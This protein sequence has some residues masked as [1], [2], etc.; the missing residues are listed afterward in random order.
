M[1]KHT[2]E[3]GVKEHAETYWNP[4]LLICTPQLTHFYGLLH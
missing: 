1:A 4:G 2:Y 3:A